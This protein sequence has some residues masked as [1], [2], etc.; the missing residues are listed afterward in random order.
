MLCHQFITN[1]ILYATNQTRNKRPNKGTP[2]REYTLI[3][4]K[5]LRDSHKTETQRAELPK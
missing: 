1:H 5:L 4:K 3:P 2:T